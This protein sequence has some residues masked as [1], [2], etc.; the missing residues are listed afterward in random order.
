MTQSQISYIILSIEDIVLLRAAITG[1]NKPV[2]SNIHKDE[3]RKAKEAGLPEVFAICETPILFPVPT[4][5]H[6]LFEFSFR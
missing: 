2:F 6:V 5:L 3:R 1:F 4:I